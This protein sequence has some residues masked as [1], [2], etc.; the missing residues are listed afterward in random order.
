MKKKFSG[1]IAVVLLLLVV[2]FA[3]C[4]QQN[5]SREACVSF[6][7]IAQADVPSCNSQSECL[8]KIKEKW[9]NSAE[10]EILSQRAFLYL[11]SF[12]NHFANSWFHY[13]ESEKLLKK[14]QGNCSSN[15]SELLQNLDELK[16]ALKQLSKEVSLASK[17]AVSFSAVLVDDLNANRIEL[18][19]EE[20]TFSDFHYFKNALLERIGLFSKSNSFVS[21][22]MEI[23]NRI[24]SAALNFGISPQTNYFLVALK[25]LL[26]PLPFFYISDG[27]IGFGLFSGFE[28]MIEKIELS[29]SA[30]QSVFLLEKIP[31]FEFVNIVDSAIS[32]DNSAFSEFSEKAKNS[33]MHLRELSETKNRLL[34][35]IKEKI[36]SIENELEKSTAFSP[37]VFDDRLLSE[38]FVLLDFP[39][40]ARTQLNSIESVSRFVSLTSIE[41]SELRKKTVFFSSDNSVPIGL[42]LKESKEILV[43]LEE[44]EHN[45]LFFNNEV[46]LGLK[47]ICDERISAIESQLSKLKQESFPVGVKNLLYLSLF[48]AKQFNE[49]ENNPASLL[50]C[51]KAIEFQADFLDAKKDYNFFYQ[52]NSS[53]AK[54]C[55]AFLKTFFLKSRISLF[56]ERFASLSLFD[57]DENPVAAQIA[58]SELKIDIEKELLKSEKIVLLEEELKLIE[59]LLKKLLF[60]QAK[61]VVSQKEYSD[62]EESYVGLEKVF[63]EENALLENFDRI[64]LLMETAVELK[65]ELIEFLKEAFSEYFEKNFSASTIFP[66]QVSTITDENI[67]TMVSFS[68]PFAETI[69][70]PFSSKI[71]LKEDRQMRVGIH[72]NGISSASISNGFLLIEFNFFS[73][74][75]FVELYYPVKSIV[76]KEKLEAIS[77]S[78]DTALFSKK[79]EIIFPIQSAKAIIAI[80]IPFFEKIK[81]DSVRVFAN[82]NSVNFSFENERII[83]VF[84]VENQQKTV[85]ETFFE[86]NNPFAFSFDDL[87][88]K[89]FDENTAIMEFS[90]SLKNQLDFSLP[91]KQVL[92]RFPFNLSGFADLKVFDAA[93]SKNSFSIVSDEIALLETGSF[94]PLEEKR[95]FAKAILFDSNNFFETQIALLVE[96]TNELSM[97]ENEFRQE[98]FSLLLKEIQQKILLLK[99]NSI[100]KSDKTRLL[101]EAFSQISFLENTVLERKQFFSQFN[102]ILREFSDKNNYFFKLVFELKNKDFNELAK[103]LFL[104]FENY[105]MEIESLKNDFS[106]NPKAAIDKAGKIVSK[107][108]N[109]LFGNKLFDEL[110]EKKE[111]LIIQFNSDYDANSDE[112]DLLSNSALLGRAKAIEERISELVFEKNPIEIVK[113]LSELKLLSKERESV[114][115]NGLIEFK[116]KSVLFNELVSVKIPA[117]LK[118]LKSLFNGVSSLLLQRINY[119]PNISLSEINAFEKKLDLLKSP[120]LLRRIS[121]SIAFLDKNDLKGFFESKK[122]FSEDFESKLNEAVS[123]NEQLEKK[124]FSIK[125]EAENLLVE[126]NSK[127]DLDEKQKNYLQKA[128]IA[129]EKEE[130]LK[131][132]SFSKAALLSLPVVEQQF[133]VPFPV[134]PL[135]GIILVTAAVKVMKKNGKKQQSKKELK[136][137][138]RVLI[139]D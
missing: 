87:T 93:G 15:S 49:G 58:C 107:A 119:L 100:G 28:K 31:Q 83:A 129:L 29:E 33:L 135:L 51:K 123:W 102:G 30:E 70:F 122:V 132:I 11:N 53:Q 43:R 98:N 115:S 67:L 6:S 136:R 131:S 133:E 52:K 22:F 128:R 139:D 124:F 38:L 13:N 121:K 26:R 94:F 96:K 44:L 91:A 112:Y 45:V 10:S 77:V 32:S 120:L 125:S 20:K 113:L 2:F 127:K 82:G 84:F 117:N 118:K 27:R 71:L 106:K 14:I 4:L 130:Y 116:E 90:F 76:S 40:T 17:D 46:L 92:A 99:Q 54:D 34:E 79:T 64:D 72:S 108:N 48:E 60:F 111:S 42:Q 126:A 25:T 73:R 134:F 101:K 19:S 81:K 66:K 138:E 109:L 63:L 1:I 61:G 88:Q 50:H 95:F 16:L 41:L 55:L 23:E 7:S 80:E 114:F 18:I 56:E 59:E 24:D 12:E 85:M 36:V 86:L 137:V 75:E 9:F 47:N 104:E 74:T 37:N 110:L 3:G 103:D 62:L 65:S 35:S 89:E 105:S 68:N 21:R 78:L 8:Q 57:S 97:V 69:S 5:V 39:S